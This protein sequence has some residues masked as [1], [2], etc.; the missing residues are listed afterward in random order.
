[1]RAAEIAGILHTQ[2]VRGSS[3]CAPTIH[4]RKIQTEARVGKGR[5]DVDCDGTDFAPL[6]ASRPPYWD[7][8]IILNRGGHGCVLC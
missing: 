3:P 2:E 4:I 6:L 7:T 8:I 5:C 1:M